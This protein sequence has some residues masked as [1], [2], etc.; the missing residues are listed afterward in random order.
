[1]WKQKLI[2]TQHLFYKLKHSCRMNAIYKII[3]SISDSPV[4]A[5]IN[6]THVDTRPAS[7]V[8]RRPV[9]SCCVRRLAFTSH[10]RAASRPTRYYNDTMRRLSDL[11]SRWSLLPLTCVIEHILVG[12]LGFTVAHC[13]MVFHPWTSSV[14]QI[15]I[16]KISPNIV[17]NGK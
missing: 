5:V 11:C 8:R 1:M 6:R 7:A 3:R 14:A 2:Q 17:V 13:R 12:T 16:D 4:T 15:N 10:N 9:G